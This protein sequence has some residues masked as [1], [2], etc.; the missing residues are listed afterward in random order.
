M[1]IS[2]FNRFVQELFSH[3]YFIQLAISWNVLKL[4]LKYFCGSYWPYMRFIMLPMRKK[5]GPTL[6]IDLKDCINVIWWKQ[7]N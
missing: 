2:F 7:R 1:G 6:K 5:I 4:Q 3:T